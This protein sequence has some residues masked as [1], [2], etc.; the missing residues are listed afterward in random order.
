MA[1]DNHHDSLFRLAFLRPAVA[2]EH[3]RSHLPATVVAACQWKT[4]AVESGSFIDPKL[5]NLQS[6]V[7]YSVKLKG[8]GELLLYVLLEHQHR[9]DYLMAFRV[10]RYMTRIWQTWLEAHSN[11][12]PL[13]FIVP[14]VLYHGE[15]NWTAALS[16][17]E[18]MPKILRIELSSFIPD[19]SYQLQDLA[20]TPD[21]QLR[22]EALRQLVLLLLKHG[23][24]TD[25][26]EKFPDWM[27]AL[28]RL[29]Q[30]PSDG[31]RAV[32]ALLRYIVLVGQDKPP[33]SIYTLIAE[34]LSPK[35]EENLMTWAEQLRQEGRQEGEQKGRQEA[36]REAQRAAARLQEQRLS[37]ARSRVQKMLTLKFQ[38]LTSQHMAQIE[39]ADEDTL[40]RWT[41]EMLTAGSV[42]ALLNG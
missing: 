8:E 28:Q 32:E 38:T 20:R 36:L 22:G 19:F 15:R 6:D 39:A 33:Q 21:E 7:L 30:G 14:M 1:R 18:L 5:K 24:S 13:P 3:F 26:W 41:I 37:Q 9:V 10:L 4:L 2:A 25:F 12:R 40:E 34:K 35:M 42:D 27:D 31:L 17:P 29:Y 16:F 23:R 11:K